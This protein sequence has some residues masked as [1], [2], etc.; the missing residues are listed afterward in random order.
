MASH[1]TQVLASIGTRLALGAYPLVFVLTFGWAYGKNA[2][3]AAA[4]ATNW[5]NYLNVLLLGGFVLV[6]PA[7][8]RLRTVERHGD[9]A[10]LVRDHIAL[11][12]WL[13][14][15]GVLVAVVLWMT[16]GRMFPELAEL[17]GSSLAT[18]FAMLAVLALAQLPMT[19]WLGVAQ[20]ADEYVRAFG[21]IVLPRAIALVVLI[22]GAHYEASATWMLFAAVAIVVA[23]QSM[24]ARAAHRVL[25]ALDSDAVKPGVAQRVLAQNVS[26]GAIGL[27]GTLVT[28]VPVTIVGRV[29][30][31]EVGHAHVVVTLSNA[32][33]AVIVAALFPLSLTLARQVR[34][35]NGLWRHWLTV[36]AP[37]LILAG[38]AR[39]PPSPLT[40]AWLQLW[41]GLPGGPSQAPNWGHS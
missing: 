24:L 37:G 5:A 8:A 4:A 2:F 21:W 38:A 29:L 26:A 6:P 1:R 31:Q 10:Q 32:V 12:R 7:V 17:A 36:W 30:P 3:D 27:V 16:I 15:A 23:G 41:T 25:A 22:V 35:P 18:W 19:L 11:E 39:C 40:A 34:E 14:L 28:I 13:L 20:A 33:G 9:D